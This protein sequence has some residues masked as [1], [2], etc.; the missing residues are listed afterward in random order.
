M[1]GG[2]DAQAT[3]GDL[4]RLGMGIP[5]GIFNKS[6]QVAKVLFWVSPTQKLYDLF[7]GIHNLKEQNPGNGGGAR[8]RAQHP[9]PAAASG[10]VRACLSLPL[11]GRVDRE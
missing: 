1:L 4:V 2:A 10:G 7:W 5:H 9:L 6:D 8:R 3:P 11:A